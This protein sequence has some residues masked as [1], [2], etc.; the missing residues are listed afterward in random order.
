LDREKL[1]L[2]S[3]TLALMEM[4]SPELEKVVFPNVKKRPKKA[5]FMA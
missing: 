4:E 1:L 5:L 2:T 3:T